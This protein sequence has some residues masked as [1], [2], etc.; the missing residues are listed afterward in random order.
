MTPHHL[1]QQVHTYLGWFITQFFMPGIHP[2][3][4]VLQLLEVLPLEARLRAFD[5]LLNRQA[6]TAGQGSD[7]PCGLGRELL[8]LYHSNQDGTPGAALEVQ[9]RQCV[10]KLEEMMDFKQSAIE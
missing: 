2:P 1:W 8:S 10:V 3:N 5:Y 4:A 9:L 6:E 7:T